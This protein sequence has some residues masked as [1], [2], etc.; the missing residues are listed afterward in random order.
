MTSKRTSTIIPT[1]II[2]RVPM[3]TVQ[4]SSS[5]RN[6]LSI[7]NIGTKGNWV[8]VPNIQVFQAV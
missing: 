8:R 6:R 5:P 7:M 3:I 2:E 1:I 4:E